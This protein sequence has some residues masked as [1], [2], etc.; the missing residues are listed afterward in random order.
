MNDLEDSPMGNVQDESL[1]RYDRLFV[2]M[3]GLAIVVLTLLVYQPAMQAGFVW[4]DDRHF[5]ANPYM[6]G[7]GGLANIWLKHDFYYPL[8]S[9]TW[10]LARRLWGLNP[11]GYHLLNILLHALNAVLLW[12]LLRRL[13]VPGAWLAGTVF[14]LHPVN[15]QS[16]AWATE[17]K[18][19][20][21]GLFY[22]L[23]LLAWTRLTEK[24]ARLRA[25]YVA[26]LVAFAAALLS[27]TSTVTLPFALVFM[28]LWRRRPLDRRAAARWAPFFALAALAALLTLA[29]HRPMV[30]GE[31][32]YLSALQRLALSAR[33]V[34]FYLGK[35]AWPLDL[36]FVYPRWRIDVLSEAAW[37]PLLGLILLAITLMGLWWRGGRPALLTLGY[38]VASLLPVLN[39]FRMY[40]ARYAYAA[41]HWQYLAGMGAIAWAV[42]AATW[43]ARRRLSERTR[44]LAEMIAGVALLSLLGGLTWRQAGIYQDSET[45]WLDVIAHH[46]DA[47]IAY[48]NLSIHYFDQNNLPMAEATLREG[49]QRNPGNPELATI[50][51]GVLIHQRRWVE[52]RSLL[53]GALDAMPGDPEILNN[54]GLVH[55]A[56]GRID[57]AV[58][59]FRRAI[60][61]DPRSIEIYN[62]LVKTLL[63]AGRRREA[64]EA[65]DEGLRALP[66]HPLLLHLRDVARATPAASPPRS[67]KH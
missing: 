3:Q 24:G 65:I 53:D 47:A 59:E 25:W 21:S 48:N 54:L 38:F 39:F 30:R 33:C 9:T 1:K 7:Q 41:D 12:R 26:A 57:Q 67:T 40:Y 29:G 17:L 18:N 16:V 43:L 8:T 49:L 6:S 52:A 46:P 19:C 10:W 63:E 50:L 35:L 64:L 15:V 60:E 20:Q 22:L 36:S 51:A 37:L 13:A 42:G 4:D 31:E 58:G 5:V 32:W 66:A 56:L 62:N 44:L 11:V 34:W 27:K 61:R 45:L 23:A 55:A 28:D 14:A 2:F